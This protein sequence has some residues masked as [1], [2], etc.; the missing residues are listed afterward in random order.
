MIGVA[1]SVWLIIVAA[2]MVGAAFSAPMVIWGTLLQ[3]RVPPHL[4]GRVASLD[5]MELNPAF[6]EHNRTAIVAVE[7]VE[8]LFGKSTL[9]RR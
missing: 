1:G 2:F 5:I 3:R 7:L 9:M 4:L 6:D 8:S